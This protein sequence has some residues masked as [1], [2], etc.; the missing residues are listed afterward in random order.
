MAA[1][2][3][4]LLVTVSGSPVTEA[5]FGIEQLPTPGSGTATVA[6]SGGT[7]PVTVPP[8]SFTNTTPSSDVA[9]G[10]VTSIRI[11]SFPTNTT[12]LTINGT[13]YT[14]GTFPAGGV[15]VTTD[16]SGNATVPILV[17]PTND[18]Q[19]VTILVKAI[20]NAGKESTTT[21]TAI[22][23]F[24]VPDLTP[25]IYA[26][27]STTYGTTN[28]SVV[29]D[30]LELNSIPT[31]G[32]VT[33]YVT[34]DTKAPLSFSSTT[35]TLN[36]RS[37]QNSLWS[38]DGTSNSSFYILTTSQVIEADGVLSFGLRGQVIPGAT[39]GVLTLSS[40]I[41]D[42]SGG[43]VRINNNSDADKIDYFNK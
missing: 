14:P 25:I 24:G 15:V 8:G 13:V 41:D 18:T 34:K 19:P 3:G 7:T 38:F 2:D 43:E 10:T 12:S 5:N 21:G 28:I 36:G 30:V 1:P 37:V 40:V 29:V 23:N 42:G 26:R 9:P 6:N 35:T 39:K 33:V 27:A 11:P 16:G 20:D 22:V 4:V 31:S 17:D 32:T